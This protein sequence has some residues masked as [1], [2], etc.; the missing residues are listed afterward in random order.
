M[1]HAF[2]MGREL[3]RAEICLYLGKTYIQNK[4]T[5]SFERLV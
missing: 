2:Y 4:Q 5:F 3:E 1:D